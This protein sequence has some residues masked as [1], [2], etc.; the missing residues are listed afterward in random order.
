VAEPQNKFLSFCCG[1]PWSEGSPEADTFCHRA[2]TDLTAFRER[3]KIS[4]Y[5]MDTQQ[6]RRKE[7]RL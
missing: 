6:V 2:S 3:V 5:Q 4:I 1:S 7:G